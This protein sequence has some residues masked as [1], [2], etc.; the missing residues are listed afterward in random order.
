MKATAGP[1]VRSSVFPSLVRVILLTVVVALAPISCTRKTEAAVKPGVSD[2]MPLHVTDENA[3]A[4]MKHV[5]ALLADEKFAELDT[6]ASTARSQRTRFHGGGWVLHTIYSGISFPSPSGG[7]DSLNAD[8]QRLEETLKKWMAQRPESVTPR[9]ALA[10]VYRNEAWRARG[11]GYADLVKEEAWKTFGDK[12]QRSLDVLTDAAGL[13]E[14]CPE[15]YS[16]M[17]NVSRD[18]QWP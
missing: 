10:G 6:M 12:E 8:W 11:E 16:L 15:W 1:V 17:I 3:D 4:Y 18:L 9:V 13:K 2:S 14:K 5:G 7:D